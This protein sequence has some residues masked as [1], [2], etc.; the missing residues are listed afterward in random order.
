MSSFIKAVRAY[1]RFTNS[2]QSLTHTWV[3]RYACIINVWGYMVIFLR[4]LTNNQPPFRLFSF[5][6]LHLGFFCLFT[7]NAWHKFWVLC[8][9]FFRAWCAS[10]MVMK[11]FLHAPHNKSFLY[12]LL[13]FVLG[14]S[15][16][17]KVQSRLVTTLIFLLLPFCQQRECLST[18]NTISS[19]F[20]SFFP[21][22]RL[23]F[24]S[25]PS[26]SSVSF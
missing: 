7:F 9:A 12:G 10:Q 5:S 20:S 15:R 22:H 23:F 11:A 26:S 2:F 19:F 25:Q 8:L 14:L 21:L 18:P 13:S 17:R 24:F 4:W 1:G 16:T 6:Q 3:M